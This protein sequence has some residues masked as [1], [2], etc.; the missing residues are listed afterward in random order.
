M[1]DYEKNQSVEILVKAIDSGNLSFQKKF[2]INITN[3]IEDLDED[4][5]EDAFDSDIDGDGFSNEQEVTFGSD[6]WIRTHL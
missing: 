4:G 6:P 1:F 5:I 2:V 3:L